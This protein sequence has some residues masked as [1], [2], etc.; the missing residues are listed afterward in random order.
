MFAHD[1]S[2]AIVS[3]T[4]QALKG[5]QQNYQV[6]LLEK[7]QAVTKEDVIS[8]FRSH[9]LPL[10]DSKSSVAVVVTAPSKA[11]AIDAGLKGY[12]FEVERRSLEIDPSEAEGSDGSDSDSGSSESDASGLH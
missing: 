7:F 8:V 10:F 9:F 6:D 12:G 3:F 4:N 2:K 5:V 1:N 11:D